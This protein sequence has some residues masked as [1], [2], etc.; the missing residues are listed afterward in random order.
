MCRELSKEVVFTVWCFTRCDNPSV[1][2][3]V[4]GDLFCAFGC[5]CF[6]SKAVWLK[7][8]HHFWPNQEI[9]MQPDTGG[10]DGHQ[11][12]PTHLQTLRMQS[13]NSGHVGKTIINHPWQGMV[14]IAPVKMVMTGGWCRWHCFIHIS[15]FSRNLWDLLIPPK[16]T[17][18]LGRFTE[19]P[20]AGREPNPANKSWIWSVTTF[21]TGTYL[22]KR[23]QKY[24]IF[25][26]IQRIFWTLPN[27]W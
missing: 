10:S 2:L 12:R 18:E 26:D 21:S 27:N 8:P 6:R 13:T 7:E 1:R 11:S 24:E 20:T 17:E 3:F 4:P 15:D 16:W 9:Q 23:S 5:S 25:M 14:P 22:P 19:H